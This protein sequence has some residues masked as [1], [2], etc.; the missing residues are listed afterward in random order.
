MKDVS[1]D[2][3]V[4]QSDF[5]TNGI[6]YA[7]GSD[8][9][10]KEWRNPMEQGLI[11]VDSHGWHD[12]TCQA[13]QVVAR[14]SRNDKLYNCTTNN[15]NGYIRIAFSNASIQPTAYTWRHDAH[16]TSHHP[17]NWNFEGSND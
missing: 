1:N 16:H 11:T 7:F 9:G 4:Y 3:F 10:T 15:Q 5:D 12:G 6:C 17:R 8:F 13:K 2:N 14:V